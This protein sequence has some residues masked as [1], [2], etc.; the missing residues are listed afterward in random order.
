MGPQRVAIRLSSPDATTDNHI[1]V[2]S[3]DTSALP[4]NYDVSETLKRG[5][6]TDSLLRFAPPQ[7]MLFVP[8]QVIKIQEDRLPQF[9]SEAEE[10]TDA[11]QV[12]A[13][14]PVTLTLSRYLGT[15]EQIGIAFECA[16]NPGDATLSGD[17]L[18]EQG[19]VICTFE[20]TCREVFQRQDKMLFVS[21]RAPGGV[22]PSALRLTASGSLAPQILAIRGRLLRDTRSP[23]PLTGSQRKSYVAP[24]TEVRIPWYQV[25]FKDTLLGQYR[26]G[27]QR[28]AEK[29]AVVPVGVEPLSFSFVGRGDNLSSLTLF[30]ATYDRNNTCDVR[31]RMYAALHSRE[32]LLAEYQLSAREVPDNK[33]WIVPLGLIPESQGRFFRIEID[34]PNSNEENQ[35]GLYVSSIRTDSLLFASFEREPAGGIDLTNYGHALL[36][37]E[38]WG[39][40]DCSFQNSSVSLNRDAVTSLLWID[41][42]SSESADDRFSEFAEALGRQGVRI[43]RMPVEKI[44]SLAT[45]SRQFDGVFLRG[46]FITSRPAIDQDLFKVRQLCLTLSKLCVPV[47][48]GDENHD[49]SS[50]ELLRYVDFVVRPSSQGVVAIEFGC[51]DLIT[52][53]LEQLPSLIATTYR[54]RVRPVCSIVS[55]L[56]GKEREVPYFLQA[57]ARQTY[58]GD[59]EII[60]VDDCSPDKS[61]TVATSYWKEL[62]ERFPKAK[63]PPLRVIKNPENRGNCGS[64]LV[65]MEQAKGDVVVI[66]DADCIVNKHFLE[67]H[68]EAFARGDCDVVIGPLNIETGQGDPMVAL[69]QFEATP[70]RALREADLQDPLNQSGFLNCVTRNFSIRA[71]FVTEELFDEIFA[72]SKKPDSGFGWEDIEMGYRLYKRGARIVFAERS[73]SLHVSHP[74]SVEEGTKPLRSLLNFKRLVIK[75]PEMQYVAR[76]W[77]LDTYGKICAWADGLG[78][79]HNEDRRHLDYIFRDENRAPLVR[80]RPRPL[81]ILTYRWHVPHQFELYKMPH[82]FSLV[83]LPVETFSNYWNYEERALPSNAHFVSIDKVREADYDLVLLHFDENCLS[84][85]NCNGVLD[86]HWGAAFRHLRSSMRLPMVAICHG[87]PQFHGQYCPSYDKADL[88]V[89]SEPERQRLVDYMGDL[90]VVC[91]SHQAQ[92]E[93]RFNRSKVI[94]QGFDP[95]QFPPS[96]YERGILTLGP[97][98]KNRP[99]Y[100]GWQVYQDILARLPKEMHPTHTRVS[101]PSIRYKA[102]THEYA[103]AKFRKYVQTLGQFSVYLNPTIRSPMPRSR[104]EAMMCGLVPVSLNNHDVEFF[105]RNGV[106]GFYAD[107]A[108]ELADYLHYLMRNPSITRRIGEAARQTASDLFNHDRYLR[109]WEKTINERVG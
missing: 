18:D 62:T 28:G 101:A 103:W 68:V 66:I 91:N 64:R 52:S 45:Y 93:W 67:A 61:S 54:K 95:T 44:D 80:T 79:P 86:S 43:D 96:S 49:Q 104:G 50:E 102:E 7:G 109:E 33:E 82:K 53:S 37:I 59:F 19:E 56:Y 88:G 11:L 69:E 71:D 13:G 72:Y 107:N 97:S 46:D 6:D 48:A 83:Q 74:P 84:P 30:P 17:L 31:V 85:E 16:G 3:S 35:I 34:S 106:N 42:T 29:L 41:I 32:Q 14:L 77:V 12:L 89:V 22:T 65:G 40:G 38:A 94:W 87:T 25:S 27:L 55:V 39:G 60:L 36:D 57:L 63:R 108:P 81:R 9:S 2:W 20:R 76:R 26:S 100:R 70:G 4:I 24:P 105:I 90:L 75:H 47:I 78:L 5:Y 21:A 99:Y 73:F 23:L 10:L 51:K 1:A 92:R 98:M 15:L 58:K 8:R